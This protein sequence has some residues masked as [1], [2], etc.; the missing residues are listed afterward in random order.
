M[1]LKPRAKVLARTVVGSDPTLMLTGPIP[2]TRRILA[3]T[4][5]SIDEM[6]SI[7]IN[8]AFASVVL[9]WEKEL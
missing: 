7:E 4:G 6:D 3:K 5:F 2:A 1:G 9:A 8:E